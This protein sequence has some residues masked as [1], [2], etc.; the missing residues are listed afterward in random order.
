[1][2][3]LLLSY[4]LVKFSFFLGGFFLI[5]KYF[6]YSGSGS[7][8]KRRGYDDG[9]SVASS[10]PDNI[11]NF[12]YLLRFNSCCK[13]WLIFPWFRSTFHLNKRSRVL[14]VCLCGGCWSQATH[15]RRENKIR[16]QELPSSLPRCWMPIPRTPFL[17]SWSR[18]RR[19]SL[20]NGT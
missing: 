3:S 13:R 16:E 19:Y 17:L 7:A 5:S 6:F 8:S 18:R 15:Y 1:M 20:P 14:L 11:C 9:P 12:A 2:S 10:N 4:P